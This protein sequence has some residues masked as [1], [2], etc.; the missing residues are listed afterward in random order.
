LNKPTDDDIISLPK[1]V[2]I[3]KNKEWHYGN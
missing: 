1:S 3:H 2:E